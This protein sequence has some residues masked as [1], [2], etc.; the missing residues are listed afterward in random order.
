MSLLRMAI[1]IFVS[2]LLSQ[3]QDYMFMRLIPVLLIGVICIE[4]NTLKISMDY[5]EFMKKMEDNNED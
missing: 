4:S 5:N 1:Y 3:L 2:I